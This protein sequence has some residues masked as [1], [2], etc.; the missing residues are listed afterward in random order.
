[1]EHDGVQNT[2][3]GM[4]QMVRNFG[5]R[6]AAGMVAVLVMM[7]GLSSLLKMDAAQAEAASV[8]A[9]VSDV[10]ELGNAK[11]SVDG[12]SLPGFEYGDAVAL[13]FSNGYEIHDVPYYDDFYGELGQTMLV[14]YMGGY[15]V[16]AQNGDFVSFS[17]VKAEDSVEI[18]LEEKEK[19]RDVYEAFSMPIILEMEEGMAPEAFAN[20][21]AVDTAEM[22]DDVL[23]RSASPVETKYGRMEVIG[24]LITQHEIQT[25]LNITD[26]AEE[27]EEKRPWTDVIERMMQEG[28]IL[29][30]PISMNM[31]DES[32][33]QQLCEALKHMFEM[34]PPYLLHCSMGRDRTGV[35]CAIL[36]ALMGGTYEEIM[37]DYILSF[38]NFH[39]LDP[40]GAFYDPYRER[41]DKMLVYLMGVESVEELT[42][43][44]LRQGAWDYLKA[45]GISDEQIEEICCRLRGE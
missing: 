20:F 30:H 15:R 1:M 26:S 4:V 34:E 8:H 25:I 32:F 23:Y 2:E 41:F 37:D 42:G 29:F 31:Y 7:T 44:A 14:N 24:Q 21:R 39:G 17:G 10:D 40:D 18:S 27:M 28:K 5:I 6:I 43:D 13:V 38:A 19:Y 3:K 35:A 45:G 11:L 12:D 22:A 33:Q 36:Q 16:A 9:V